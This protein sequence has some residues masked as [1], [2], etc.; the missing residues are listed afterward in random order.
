MLPQGLLFSS[1]QQVAELILALLPE[2]GIEVEHRPDVFSAIEKLT[3]RSYDLLVVDWKDP[4]EASFLLK[5]AR[6]LSMARATP[7]IAIVD[8]KD[9]SAALNLGA[10]GV[11]I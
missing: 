5:T 1:D 8:Q 2:F 6:E 4:L 3:G 11:L 9:S 7:A 10:S